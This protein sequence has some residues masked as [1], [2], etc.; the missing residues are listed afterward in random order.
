MT[1]ADG[2]CVAMEGKT[3]SE[4]VMENRYDIASGK[5][6]PREEINGI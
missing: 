5:K 4:L 1:H 6:K 3:I 2:D